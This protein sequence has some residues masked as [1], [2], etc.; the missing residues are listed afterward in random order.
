VSAKE[1]QHIGDVFQT[2]GKGIKERLV[3]EEQKD[4]EETRNSNN[5]NAKLGGDGNTQ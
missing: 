2:L 3:K 5:G 4:A 1:N